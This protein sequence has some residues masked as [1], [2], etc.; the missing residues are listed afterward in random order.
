MAFECHRLRSQNPE[1]QALPGK[2]HTGQ[3][4]VQVSRRGFN[5]TKDARGTGPHC[6][7]AA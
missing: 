3:D 1:G 5:R 2:G 7:G 4:A 6:R